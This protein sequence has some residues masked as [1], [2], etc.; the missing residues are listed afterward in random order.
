MPGGDE[1]D[2]ARAT[3]LQRRLAARV[4]SR[5]RMDPVRLIAGADVAYGG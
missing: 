3:A 5:D 1:F 2:P 4:E